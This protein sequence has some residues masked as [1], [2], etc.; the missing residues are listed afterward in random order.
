MISQVALEKK[1]LAFLEQARQDSFNPHN[2]P[3]SSDQIA[4]ELKID[5]AQVES[6]CDRLSDTGLV[7]RFEVGMIYYRLPSESLQ[8]A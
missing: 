7:D 5:R 1:I 8:N 6:I 2:Y 3:V 4:H